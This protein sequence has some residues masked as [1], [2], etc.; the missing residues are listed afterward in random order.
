MLFCNISYYKVFFCKKQACNNNIIYRSL[1][2]SVL[3]I[4]LTPRVQAEQLAD[5]WEI[6]KNNVAQ[7]WQAPQYHDI[8]LPAVTWHARFA[9]DRLHTS[10][11]NE[12]PWGAGVGLTRFD[13]KNN[14][15]G[16]YIMAFK[17]SFKKWEPII[18]Y[19]WEA[20]W[21]PF[22]NPFTL[23]LGYTTGITARDNWRYIPIPVPLPLASI[24]YGRLSLQMTYI[25]GLY[26]S[27]NVYFAWLRLQ[28]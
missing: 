23:G 19:G 13:E 1:V 3:I 15:H 26:N 4:L 7:T 21:H 20:R 2:F 9:Y 10:R 8:Y 11:Y 22:D 17:D 24:G 14:W 6:Y 5:W 28:L 27:G 18:G 16:L 12:R 25:P